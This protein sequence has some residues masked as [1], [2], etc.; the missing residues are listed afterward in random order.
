MLRLAVAA[1]G[2]AAIAA[3]A[4][5]QQPE[6]IPAPAVP[7][8]ME[9]PN[10]I[11]D[12][13]RGAHIVLRGRG[14]GVED[15]DCSACYLCHDREGSGDPADPIPRVAGQSFLYLYGELVDFAVG[16][17][18]SHVMSPIAQGLSDDA[19]RDVA[20]YFALADPAVEFDKAAAAATSKFKQPGK[21]PG[22]VLAEQGDPGRGLQPCAVCHGPRGIGRPPMFPYLA[23]Q[24]KKYLVDRLHAF[25]SGEG[26]DSPGQIMHEIARRLTDKEIEELATYYA[27]QRPVQHPPQDLV[28]GQ[29]QPD[30]DQGMPAQGA[31]EQRPQKD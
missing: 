11:P 26:V 30:P 14:C 27:A 22:S 17:R 3:P 21:V 12:P 28:P 1:L 16:A 18:R 4:V 20:A 6:P 19:M 25:R 5:S 10:G 9:V 2:L 23:G 29:Y 7:P 8:G 31:A 15:A 13:K 24:Y